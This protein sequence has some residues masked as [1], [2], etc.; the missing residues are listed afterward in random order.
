MFNHGG[1]CSVDSTNYGTTTCTELSG[2]DIAQI[3]CSTKTQLIGS[4][5]CD[6]DKE[7]EPP[8]RALD[9]AEA[10]HPEEDEFFRPDGG[11]RDYPRFLDANSPEEDTF[12]QP[13]EGVENHSS[14]RDAGSPETLSSGFHEMSPLDEGEWAEDSFYLEGP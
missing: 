2:R 6:K 10:Q 9:Y 5:S 12:F 1:Y 4:T 11:A 7:A 13:D 14:L 8:V 3:A